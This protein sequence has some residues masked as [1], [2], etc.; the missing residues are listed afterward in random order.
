M[1]FNW[2]NESEDNH[3]QKANRNSIIKLIEEIMKWSIE[4]RKVLRE[5]NEKREKGR[6]IIENDSEKERAK[7]KEEYDSF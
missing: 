5:K 3:K 2:E 7:H 1:N 4:R 6:K